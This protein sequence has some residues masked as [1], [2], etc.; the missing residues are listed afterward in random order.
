MNNVDKQNGNVKYSDAEHVYWDD[1]GK[2]ISVTTLIGHYCQPFDKEF[3]SSYKALEKLLSK[4]DFKMEKKMLLDTKKV[5]LKYY[6]DMY[7]ITEAEYNKAKQDILDTWQKENIASCERGTKIHAELEKSILGNKETDLKKYGFGGKFVVNTNESLEKNN[8]SLL[9]VERGVFPEFLVYRKSDDGILKVAGQIDLLVK[10]GNDIYIIDYKGLPLDT[11]I[12]TTNG[13]STIGD[14]KVGDKVFDKNGK[15]TSIVHK[16]EIHTNPCYK[17]TFDNGDSIVADHEHRWEITFK[18]N[19]TKENPDGYKSVI[20]TTEDIY[21]YL[22]NCERTSNTI[23]KILNPKPIVSP[24][25][26]LPIDPYVL[27]VWLGDGSKNCGGITQAKGSPV[28]EEIRNR[29]YE[30][31][32]NGQH[33]P[34]REN[35][36]MRTVYG[37]RTLLR[38][39]GILSQKDIPNIYY[40]A[41]YNQR[42]DLLRG[43]MDTD[44]YYHAGRKRFV[45]STGQEWQRD[46]L[47][48]LLGTLGIKSTVFNSL[49]KCG[50]KSFQA[51]DICFSTNG[52]NP[53]LVR[54]K[55]IEFPTRDKNS[56]RNIKSVECCDIVPTQCI[57][58]DSPTHTFLCT[59]KCIV[60]HNTNKKLEEKSYYNP[61]T[62]KFT[63]MKYP[64]SNL[65]DCNML[66]YTMQL[67]TY[68]WMIQ[69]LNPKFNIRQ[70]KIIHFDHQ[71]NVKE[72]EL[73]YLKKEVERMLKDYKKSIILEKRKN[74]RKPIEF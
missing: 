29:G 8:T 67:S 35:V 56:F 72:H 30:V 40:T 20:M 33:N 3:W 64:L 22:Q 24:D 37:L 69:K 48:K 68:A 43:F 16:S 1:E 28:W 17:I 32:E 66:H 60:T 47:V 36:E 54:N 59:N 39:L 63:M 10:D 27:G 31:G 61:T 23:P 4:E 45:M 50:D 21:K 51:W 46:C 18:C 14:L 71:G 25:K 13:W 57:E 38:H 49:R 58:V 73:N 42:L 12:L 19:K 74:A 65:M 44:G 62:K 34:D 53:F 26:D 52:I 9:D 5:H 15:E 11:E 55:E 41:S 7:N 6:I 70:L 2:Y